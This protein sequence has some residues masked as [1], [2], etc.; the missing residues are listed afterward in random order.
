MELLESIYEIE[1]FN[2]SI[3]YNLI[4]EQYDILK[5]ADDSKKGNRILSLLSGFIKM[6]GNI[7]TNLK[8][9]LI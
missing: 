8:S 7:I 5:E 4:Q 3:T 1:C 9:N 6:I 2:Q